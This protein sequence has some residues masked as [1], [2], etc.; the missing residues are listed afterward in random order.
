[1]LLKNV[2]IGYSYTSKLLKVRCPRKFKSGNYKPDMAR[3]Y[4][5]ENFRSL[6]KI[7]IHNSLIGVKA[8]RID[9]DNFPSDILEMDDNVLKRLDALKAYALKYKIELSAHASKFCVLGSNR[10]SVRN[11]SVLELT[12]IRNLLS[13]ISSGGRTVVHVGGRY[14]DKHA[15]V[16]RFIHEVTGLPED[17]RNS[18]CVENDDL[19][20]DFS[21]VR[22][23]SRECGIP[24]VFDV[25]HNRFNGK[26]DVHS[27]VGKCLNSWNG[28]GIAKI[29]FSSWSGNLRGHASTINMFEFNNFLN[30]LELVEV[31]DKTFVRV[32]LEVKDKDISAIKCLSL[33]NVRMSKNKV[34]ASIEEYKKFAWIFATMDKQRCIRL[35]DIL[36]SSGEDNAVFHFVSMLNQ[37]DNL[38]V[39]DNLTMSVGDLNGLPFTVDLDS[40]Y[41]YIGR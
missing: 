34:I 25:M 22:L 4:L 33:L 39:Y 40:S 30:I 12:R 3:S 28:K 38:R 18:V 11:S 8:F 35:F 15:T 6:G 5:D 17:I 16:E 36:A 10:E 21:D 19:I 14:N 41:F 7:L 1:M 37:L 9:A 20:Y 26:F 27:S 23:I 2:S 31:S 29:H 32:M 13:A 24:I